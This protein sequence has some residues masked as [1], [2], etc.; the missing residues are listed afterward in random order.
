[1][2]NL[3][4]EKE[5]TLSEEALHHIML[6]DLTERQ[7][8][9]NGK[10][11]QLITVI[12]GGLHTVKG[13]NL[14]LAKRPNIKH[15]LFF[16]PDND[17]KWYYARMLQ[18]GVI[19]LRLPKEAFQSKA[20]KLTTFPESYY[21][22]GYLWKTLFPENFKREDIIRSIDE[23]LLNQDSAETTTD[24]II[25]YTKNADIFKVLKIRIQLRGLEIMSAFPTWG[26]PMT[27]NNGK[28][29]S[30]VDAINTVISGSSKFF[31]QEYEKVALL[32]D[33]YNE[34]K[35][36]ELYKATPAFLLNRTLAK[37]DS[38]RVSHKT[39]RDAD[40]A[41][42]ALQMSEEDIDKLCSLL[43]RD[44]YL[45]YP[46]TVMNFIFGRCYIRLNRQRKLKNAISLYQNLLEGL[47]V[48]NTWDLKNETQRTIDIIER[49][50]KIRF[51]TT[52]GLDQWELKRLSNV[53]I[54]IVNS[55]KDHSITMRILTLLSQSP[56][57]IAFYM[58]FNMNTLF[59]T[60]LLLIGIDDGYDKPLT[61]PHFLQYIV[62]NMGINYTYNFDDGFNLEIA[63]RIQ[64]IAGAK[65]PQMNNYCVSYAVAK[66]FNLFIGAL[67]ILCNTITIDKEYI[68]VLDD[69]LYDYHR[70]L[71]ANVQ[72]ILVKHNDIF[73]VHPDDYE[74]GTPEFDLFTKAKHEHRFLSTMKRIM[75]EALAEKMELTGFKKEAEEI[76]SK[77]TPMLPEVMKIP[78][79][80]S[81]PKYEE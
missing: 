31:L 11:T 25:G 29:F 50:L 5:Y 14:F 72:R 57:R 52:G 61:Y 7:E 48:L 76:A 65:V 27:G 64:A 67:S 18:N 80:S 66:D 34:D 75:V 37:N 32:T 36:E 41:N 13:V 2:I 9:K 70:C 35:L 79:P 6:G 73:R 45:R 47:M 40:L 68:D 62:Q 30:H 78:M 8:R 17:E 22:S 69:I 58:E 33:G 19:L 39:L 16:E 26:Q 4:P 54:H 42:Q 24:L 10:A 77:Y 15:G 56:L 51:I 55:Y 60:D 74:Y 3:G 38:V 12:G 49:L 71:A 44:E 28:P 1:M 21:K 46:F 23:A 81:V 59:K 20:A 53:I 63:N 43:Y